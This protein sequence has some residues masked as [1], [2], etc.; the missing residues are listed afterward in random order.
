MKTS[1]M[2]LTALC[3]GIFCIANAQQTKKAVFHSLQQVGL[4]N[5]RGA[6][7]ASLQSINGFEA[8]DWFAGIG[9]GLDF[10]RY[11][12]VP[13]FADVKRYFKIANGNRLFIY[14]DGG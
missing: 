9:L 5:G 12:S 6:V 2:I 11:R 10:Y 14:G 3:C 1:R 13:L 7:S 4:I 8:G